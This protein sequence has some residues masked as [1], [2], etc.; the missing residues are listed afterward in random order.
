MAKN[1]C[2]YSDQVCNLLCRNICK[3]IIVKNE[4]VIQ[5]FFKQFMDGKCHGEVINT[6]CRTINYIS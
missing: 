3:K 2:I 5:V 4:P 6:Q 1:I